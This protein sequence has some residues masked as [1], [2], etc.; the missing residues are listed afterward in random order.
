MSNELNL[1]KEETMPINPELSGGDN[2]SAA[3]GNKIVPITNA[4][5]DT[6][7]NNSAE[8][9][10]TA[11]ALNSAA[12]ADASITD[13]SVAVVNHPAA[14][15]TGN[16]G[17]RSTATFNTVS[18]SKESEAF[19]NSSDTAGFTT[20]PPVPDST[21][22]V[23]DTPVSDDTARERTTQSRQTA[24][25]TSSS[26]YYDEESDEE[27]HFA[28]EERPK[29]PFFRFRSVDEE[30]SRDKLILSRIKDEDLMEY[31]ALEQRRLEF[32]QQAKETKQ[33][34]LLTAFQLFISLA[35][36]V[37]V[38]Y[39]LQDNPTIL[40]SI[41]YIVGIIAALNIWKNPHD[42]GKWRK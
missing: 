12:D 9:V 40:I 35:A 33:K 2:K 25:P 21:V 24:Q 31:L 30:E 42:K 27:F 7:A 14:A 23:S 22:S 18:T 29:R 38:T 28:D 4:V 34:R 11:A 17:N 16:A 10:S 5:I 39:L 1:T 19:V 3:E 20:T 32:L 6:M 15:D 13:D 37:A 26:K 8:S 36:I 41:L